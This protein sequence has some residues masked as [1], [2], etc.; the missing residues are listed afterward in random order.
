MEFIELKSFERSFKRAGLTDDDMMKLQS[1]I[2]E[3]PEVGDIEEGVRGLRKFRI[4][5]TKNR[6]KSAGARI[7]F[8]ILH[9]IC[10]LIS[11]IPKNVA[12]NLTKAERNEIAKL[13][14]ELKKFKKESFVKEVHNMSKTYYDYL[15]EGLQ[16]LKDYLNG[17]TSKGKKCTMKML[18]P[19]VAESKEIKLKIRENETDDI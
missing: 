11:F 7:H 6:G 9:D 10:Y 5:T 16:D 17:D 3:N 14:G 13:V 19:S 12:G 1:E 18:E 2:I 15:K 8:I 4:P